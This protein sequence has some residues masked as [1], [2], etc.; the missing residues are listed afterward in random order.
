MTNDI[1]NDSKCCINGSSNSF[2]NDLDIHDMI[3]ALNLEGDAFGKTLLDICKGGDS[4]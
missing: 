1:T 3:R 2:T 4:E